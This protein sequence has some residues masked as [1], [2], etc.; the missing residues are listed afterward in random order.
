V[1]D[2]SGKFP[3]HDGPID[4]PHPK[5][6]INL[7]Q[8]LLPMGTNTRSKEVKRMEAEQLKAL[9]APIKQR[10]RDEPQSAVVKV[11]S[12]GTLDPPSLMCRV[13]TVGGEVAAGLHPAAGGDGSGACS[14]DMLLDALVACAGVT[15]NA[16]ATSMGIAIRGGRISAEGEMD[17]RGTLGISKEVP[18]GLTRVQLQFMLD[19]DA[20]AAQLDKLIQL[21]E[22][23]CVIY[24]TLQHAPALDS[25]WSRSG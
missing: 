23:Y 6:T 17:F 10:Y 8:H 24:Q 25:D 15:L 7:L 11:R 18:V 22:R 1:V 16:V 4:P 14:G 3:Q 9:Q 20:E 5:A 2:C 21:T 12:T 19:T 13:A